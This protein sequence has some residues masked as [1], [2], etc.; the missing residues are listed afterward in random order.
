MENNT[1]MSNDPYIASYYLNFASV[2]IR[3]PHET[4]F[5]HSLDLRSLFSGHSRYVVRGAGW[6]R[7]ATQPPSS[8]R[9]RPSLQQLQIQ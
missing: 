7:W 5:I 9:A 1:Q 6:D 3:R 8:A 4:R 2:V